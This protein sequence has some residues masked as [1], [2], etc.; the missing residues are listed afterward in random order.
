MYIL[1]KSNQYYGNSL[2]CLAQ[3]VL[4][5][6]SLELTFMKNATYYIQIHIRATAIKCLATLERSVLSDQGHRPQLAH[7][8]LQLSEG[9]QGHAL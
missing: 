2:K 7:P 3:S 1:L 4:F 9:L 8:S 5:F 6:K